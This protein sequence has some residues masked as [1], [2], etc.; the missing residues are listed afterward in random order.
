[1]LYTLDQEWVLHAPKFPLT[2]DIDRL[3]HR[4]D[5]DYRFE[6]YSFFGLPVFYFDVRPPDDDMRGIR[7]RTLYKEC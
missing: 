1:M 3:L 7:W 4:F 6:G 5:G 2:H